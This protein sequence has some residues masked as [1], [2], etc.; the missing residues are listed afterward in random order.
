MENADNLGPVHE[1]LLAVERGDPVHWAMPLVRTLDSW[2]CGCALEWATRLLLKELP[3]YRPHH[4]AREQAW[5]KRLDHLRIAS[6]DSREVD[7][8]SRDIWYSPEHRDEFQVAVARLYGALARLL[9][10]NTKAYLREVAS[11]LSVVGRSANDEPDVNFVR[12]AIELFYSFQIHP[13]DKQ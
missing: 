9:T 5:L 4:S 6:R 10:G 2:K 1:A 8:L 12:R 7:K 3:H 11:A 13:P